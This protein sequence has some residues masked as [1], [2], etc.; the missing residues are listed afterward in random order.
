[1]G[2]SLSRSFSIP[3]GLRKGYVLSP[4][5]FSIFIMDLAEEQERKGLRVT[6]KG[7][8]LVRGGF[9]EHGER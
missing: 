2:G 4:L 5:F 6:I 9:L 1:M 7:R 8:S 3:T